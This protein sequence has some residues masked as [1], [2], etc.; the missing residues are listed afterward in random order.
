MMSVRLLLAA[1]IALSPAMLI[2][3]AIAYR[4]LA[5]RG[6]RPTAHTSAITGIL[7]CG[8]VL[9]AAV[10]VL[11]WQNGLPLGSVACQLLY[12]AAVTAATGILYVDVVN[13]A[14]TS[15]HMHLM[16]RMA[17]GE[18]PSLALLLEQ[19][20]PDRIVAERLDRLTAL[21]QI[22]REG[23]R[24]F[25][26]DRTTLRLARAIDVWRRVIGLPTSPDAQGA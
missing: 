20:S 24:Y 3:H 21:G 6:R 26:A 25:V 2:A 12:S 17:W 10:A 8:G 19:Y 9:L 4:V 14:E 1:L 23:D 11:G 13:V 5:A 15:L 18:R 7:G 16:L 22:R